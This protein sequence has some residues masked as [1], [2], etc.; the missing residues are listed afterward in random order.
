[1]ALS[2][3]KGFWLGVVVEREKLA[4]QVLR[5]GFARFAPS[6]NLFSLGVGTSKRTNL[7][8]THPNT[9]SRFLRITFA[10]CA[11]A[12]NELS[13]LFAILAPLSMH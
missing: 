1:M 10:Y 7:S 5:L 13:L 2:I 11:T 12:R 9:F 3:I 8:N 6:T 4:T